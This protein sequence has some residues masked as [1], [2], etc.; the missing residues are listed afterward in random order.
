MQ[1]GEL[2]ICHLIPSRLA[3]LSL[4]RSYPSPKTS[5]P[6]RPFRPTGGRFFG[7]EDQ[8]LDPFSRR[9]CRI[10]ILCTTR[11]HLAFLGFAA[12]G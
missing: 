9:C 1:I 3:S 8:R 11:R 2:G 4:A 10:L 7:A 6:W 5:E 12:R